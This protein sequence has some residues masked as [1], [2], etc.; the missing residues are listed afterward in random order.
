MWIETL[1]PLGKTDPGLRAP[2]QAMDLG[3]VGDDARLLEQLGYDGIAVEETKED[4]YVVMAL[5]ASATT[6]LN[7]STAI[8]MAFPRSPTVTALSA[9]TVQ[10][11]SKGRF[12]LGLGSQVRGH[13]Q[14]R[15]GMTWHAPGPWMRDYVGA[16]RAVWD[17]WQNRTRLQFE[18]EH[19]RLNLMVPLFDPGPIE[20]PDIPIHLAAVNLGM[21]RIAGEVADGL[22]PHPVCTPKY[23]AEQML[24][25]VAEGARRSGRDAAKVQVAMKPL[26]ATAPDED[27]LAKKI[28]D[29]RARVAFYAST[30]AYRPAFDAHGLGALADEMAVLSKAQRWDEMPA[31]ISD[32]ILHTYATVGTYDQIGQRL[33][34]R[35]GGLIQRIEFSI[36]CNSEAD[37]ER[38]RD[39]V[40]Q[41]HAA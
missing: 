2:E 34:E 28:V 35:Y 33:A 26:I 3:R 20:H 27:A 25:A 38:M 37:K 1:L 24:P 14:R 21:C 18:S 9:W 36:A 16:L 15:Y 5:A 4:P 8:A 23:I 31:M 29:V 19:Y 41:I 7:L 13:I 30:P 32:D 11:L 22:R 12:T 39:L 6:K 10:R 17:C 40:R